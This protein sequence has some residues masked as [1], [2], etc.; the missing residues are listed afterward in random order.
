MSGVDVFVVAACVIGYALVAR[1]LEHLWVS[2]PMVFVSLGIIFDV[3]DVVGLGVA[4]DQVA[5]LAEITLAVILFGDAVRMN[6]GDLRRHVG[7]P[8]RL[9]L[10]GLPLSIVMGSVVNWLL[11]GGLSFWAAALVAAVLAPTDAAV[12]EAIVS[13]PSVPHRIRQA[14]NV[15]AGLNDGMVVPAVV[16]CTELALGETRSGVDWAGFV[17]RQ[18]GGGLALGVAIGAGVAWLIERSRRA[19]WI[20]GMYAQVATVAVAVATF[21]AA[22]ELGVNAFVAA[23]VAGLAFGTVLDDDTADHLDEYTSDSGVLLGAIAFFVFGNLFVVDAF[24]SVRPMVVVCAVLA[25]TIGRLVPVAIATAFMGLR[26]QTVVFIGWF[27]PR[28]LASIVF[29]VI[30]L[31]EDLPGGDD[32]FGVITFTVLAS[33][34]LHGLS[35]T[36]GAAAYGRWYSTH[37]GADDDDDMAEAAPAADR[38]LRR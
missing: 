22:G 28:G 38:R 31:E 9:L 17:S 37:L 23:F 12:G 4:L 15:E 3:T 6:L 20:E 1:R 29:G 2:M 26:R 36:P 11:L 8:S 35:A 21:A 16:L 10:I 14:L 27:G 7:L 25:L 30:L 13:D 19:G 18:L 24:R 32:L 5:V 33:I 34:V